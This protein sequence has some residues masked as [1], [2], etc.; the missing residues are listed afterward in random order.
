LFKPKIWMQGVLMTTYIQRQSMNRSQLAE[1][2]AA[3]TMDVLRA[4]ER[5]HRF[6]LRFA[7]EDLRT[8]STP[9]FQ[10]VLAQLIAAAAELQRAG[11]TPRISLRR[12]AAV[13]PR[14]LLDLHIDGRDIEFSSVVDLQG[15]A[16]AVCCEAGTTS[17]I[18]LIRRWDLGSYESPGVVLAHR[19]AVAEFVAE[20]RP[21]AA[22]WMESAFQ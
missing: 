17:R 20:V 19:V 4:N 1:V 15:H 11:G 12:C 8:R 9:Y 2:R 22:V 3:K 13:A 14:I 7:A 18:P 21:S 6:G 10:Q 16:Y 5:A